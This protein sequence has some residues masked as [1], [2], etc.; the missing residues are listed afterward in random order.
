MIILEKL[1]FKDGK[2]EWVDSMQYFDR[3]REGWMMVQGPVEDTY[4]QR[5]ND[6]TID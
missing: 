6:E 1:M 2:Q 3:I 5:E 4:R